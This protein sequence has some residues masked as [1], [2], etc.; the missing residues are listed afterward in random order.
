MKKTTRQDNQEKW[1]LR[2]EEYLSK[3]ITQSDFCQ[4][5]ELNKG[6]FAY[7]LR[8]HRSNS[9]PE[10][11]TGFIAL[12]PLGEPSPDFVGQQITLRRGAVE[13]SFSTL[14]NLETLVPLIKALS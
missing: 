6:T 10:T 8:K 12:Q 5:A 14:P 4:Q 2:I 11:Q 1:F 7:W 9:E 3:G 13:L